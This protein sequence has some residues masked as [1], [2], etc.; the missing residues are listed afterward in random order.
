MFARLQRSWDLTKQ[1]AAVLAREK[2]LMLFPLLSGIST[3]LICIS[4]LVP[5]F[6]SGQLTAVQHH[7]ATPTSYATLFLFY[8]CSYFVTIYFNCALMAAAN[9]ALSG[10]HA[11]LKDGLSLANQRIA[12]ILMWTLVATTV[13]IILRTLEERAG[14]FGQI[15]IALLGAAWSI[16]TYFMVPIIVFEDQDVFAGVRRSASLVKKTWGEGVGKSLTFSAF[17]LLGLIPMFVLG[18]V[19]FMIHPLVGV[20]F[21]ACYFIVLLT[22]ISAMD[23]IFK[24][25][26]YRYPWSGVLPNEFTPDLVQGA[27]LSKK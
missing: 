22:A 18:Y 8:F 17:T 7:Q 1:S 27:F 9:M 4:F 12:Q 10:G 3:I 14:R 20:L 11:T 24:V 21:V 26:L 2:V 13:G 19:T 6:R 25:A 23:G 15:I 16:L 5:L